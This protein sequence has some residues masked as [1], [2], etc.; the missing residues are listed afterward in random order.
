MNTSASLKQ[1]VSFWKSYAARN[2]SKP[3]DTP[4]WQRDFWD[5]QL[6]KEE[7][8]AEKWQ[9]VAENPVRARLVAEACA[10]RYQGEVHILTW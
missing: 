7:N 8:Y 1:W 6:R 10:W 9:Y 5:T 4:V 3:D 2:W